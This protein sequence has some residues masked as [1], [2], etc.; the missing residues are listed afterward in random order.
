[1]TTR[2]VDQLRRRWRERQLAGAGRAGA[3]SRRWALERQYAY[4]RSHKLL[5]AG[6]GVAGAAASPAVLLLQGGFRW[7]CLGAWWTAVVAIAVH[8]VVVASGSARLVMGDWAEQWTQQELRPAR[9]AGWK[10]AHHVRF[11][12]RKDVDT[13]ALGSAGLVVV[14]TKST[15]EGW[16]SPEKRR[17]IDNAVAQARRNAADVG[18]Q[19]RQQIGPVPTWPVVVLWPSDER[20]S[21]PDVGGVTVL[22]GL[23]LR[24]WIESLPDGAVAPDRVEAAWTFLDRH[25]ARRDARD[26]EVDGPGP[27]SPRRVAAD[28]LQYPAGAFVA[29]VTV[30]LAS[31]TGWALEVFAAGA[32]LAAAVVSSRFP[33]VRRLAVATL[34]ATAGVLA[35]EAAVTMAGSIAA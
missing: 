12:P 2:T 18:R 20:L 28:A 11:R 29:V 31:A 19:V 5:L 4:A 10:V 26:L 1:V 16:T 35:A 17:T 24:R 7:F 34:V 13:I 25:V 33:A 6:I 14:E 3:A 27:R 23:E 30:G 15:S 22:P 32:L 8:T 9:R 21:A